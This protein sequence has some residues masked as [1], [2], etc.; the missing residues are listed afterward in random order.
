MSAIQR[1]I[2]IQNCHWFPK[3]VS[4]LEG[5]PLFL[6]AIKGFFYETMTMIPSILRNGFGCREDPLYSLVSQQSQ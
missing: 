2:S 3:V 1:S 6:S 4:A 5:C